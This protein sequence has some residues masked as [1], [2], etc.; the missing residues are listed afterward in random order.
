MPSLNDEEEVSHY[1]FMT[2][3]VPLYM[4]VNNMLLLTVGGENY[5]ERLSVIPR[6]I[7]DHHIDSL[8]G[9]F[10]QRSNSL[11]NSSDAGNNWA[12]LYRFLAIAGS[13]RQ[14]FMEKINLPQGPPI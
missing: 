6:A 10:E 1:F 11:T 8:V 12:S 13:K 5:N 9:V 4:F 14:P 7:I 2:K 3:A